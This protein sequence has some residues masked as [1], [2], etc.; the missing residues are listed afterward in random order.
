MINDCYN[1]LKNS[2][3]KLGEILG[4]F[5]VVELVDVDWE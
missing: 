1:I 3:V 2:E 4:V 5:D